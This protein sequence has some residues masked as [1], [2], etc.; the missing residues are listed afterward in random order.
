MIWKYGRT[1]INALFKRRTKCAPICAELES[2]READCDRSDIGVFEL[3]Y[4]LNNM[5]ITSKAR[6]LMRKRCRLG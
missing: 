3:G 2:R 6:D 1:V 5:E 4:P